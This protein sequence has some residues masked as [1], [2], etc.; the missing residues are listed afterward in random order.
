MNYFG[1][2]ILII[3][4]SSLGDI[5]HTFPMVQDIKKNYPHAQIDWL[6][7]SSFQDLIKINPNI[8]EIITIPLRVWSKDKF[9]LMH[10]II[11]WK[12]ALQVKYGKKYYDYIIDSQGLLKSAM[13]TKCFNGNIYGLGT[14]SIREK[15]AT[16][17]YQ[18]R[19][20]T[21]KEHLAIQKNRLLAAKIFNY[22]IDQAHV[23]FGLKNLI[24]ANDPDMDIANSDTTCNKQVDSCSQINNKAEKNKDAS[25]PS[26]NPGST[27]NNVVFFHSTSKKSKKYPIANWVELAE[28]LI[29]Q[30]NLQVILPFGSDKER[31]ESQQIKAALSQYPNMV[32]VPEKIMSYFEL[33]ELIKAAYFIFG[34]DTGLVHLANALNKKLIAIY[35][36]TN[37][38]KTGIFATTRA[39]NIGNIGKI[40]RV[41]KIIDLFNTL[42]K[43]E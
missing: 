30:H 10:N 6:V 3:R 20:E 29:T 15:L 40:P 2:N 11:P 12:R 1:M 13:L 9:A 26:P 24:P 35:T 32:T 43:A 39:Q 4:L 22:T 34:V 27:I 21:G 41:E 38:K 14:K 5:L 17:F 36:D 16:L 31:E 7:D 18:N 8:N 37:P 28:Y 23:N 25:H 33:I 42:I 19:I